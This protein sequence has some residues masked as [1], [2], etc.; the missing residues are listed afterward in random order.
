MRQKQKHDRAGIRKII[1][2]LSACGAAS[3]LGFAF[4]PS[5]TLLAATVPVQLVTQ[6]LFVLSVL[7]VGLSTV[8]ISIFIG[9]NRKLRKAQGELIS[10]KNELFESAYT[11]S[12][13]GLPNRLHFY[14]KLSEISKNIGSEVSDRDLENEPGVHEVAV[15]YA[16]IDDFKLINEARGHR[17]GDLLLKMIAQEL[18]EVASM[19]EDVYVARIGGDEF[20]AMI[21]NPMSKR[22]T[23]DLAERIQ[24]IFCRKYCIEECNF[25]PTASIGISRFP[26]DTGNIFDL[27]TNADM[28]LYEAKR[29]GKN[30]YAFYNPSMNEIMKETTYI[31]SRIPEA[32]Q[33]GQFFLLYQPQIDYTKHKLVGYEALL[34]WMDPDEGLIMPAHFVPI[35][36]KTGQILAVGRW[37]LETACVFARKVNEKAEAPIIIS[38]NISPVQLI[39]KGFFDMVVDIIGKTSVRPSWIGLEITETTLITSLKQNAD[40]LSRLQQMGFHVYLDDFGTGYS[41]IH[42]L[43]ELPIETVKIDQTF[44][45]AVGESEDDDDLLRL[46][47]HVAHLMKISVMA[48]GVET[49]EQLDFLEE[50][51]CDACQGFLFGHPISEEEV[52]RGR[53]IPD[54]RSRF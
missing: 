54:F 31:Q 10:S 46:I 48:E 43:R 26:Q 14:H 19:G 28:A 27:V 17:N 51:D 42:Y 23:E 2:F 37:V 29:D 18:L 25:Y 53:S 6:G 3:S 9:E 5:K 38:V 11:D 45:N 35:I 8:L 52:F 24:D 1:F 34:R 41:S 13:T 32:L 47:I 22:C 20:V 30:R 50:N 39:Q 49:V 36:E 7:A 33:K 44:V 40:V 4:I 12:L 15:V 21:Q 16:D